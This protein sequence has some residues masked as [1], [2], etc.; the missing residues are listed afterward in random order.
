M[1]LL[2][3]YNVCRNPKMRQMGTQKENLSRPPKLR[4]KPLDKGFHPPLGASNYVWLTRRQGQNAM[5]RPA[6]SL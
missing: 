1:H 6:M 2:I 4:K 5:V 3:C